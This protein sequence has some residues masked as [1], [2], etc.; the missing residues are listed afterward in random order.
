[1]EKQ[2]EIVRT[3]YRVVFGMDF[4]AETFNNVCGSCEVIGVAFPFL[5][6]SLGYNR[7]WMVPSVAHFLM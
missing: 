6:Y 3:F 4:R 7:D 2:A 1:M 5:I